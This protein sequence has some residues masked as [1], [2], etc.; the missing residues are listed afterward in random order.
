MSDTFSI[1]LVIVALA[2][3]AILLYMLLRTPKDY[4]AAVN[5]KLIVLEKS[6]QRLEDTV[7]DEISKNREEM[8]VTAKSARQEVS[9]SI[10][11]LA[12]S[13]ARRISEIGTAQKDQLDSLVKQLA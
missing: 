13:N 4:S 11:A 12:D 7:K 6:Q 3:L 2:N 8:S 5:D 9:A 1:V 10:G